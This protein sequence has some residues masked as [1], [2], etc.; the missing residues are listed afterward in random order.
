MN[1]ER[2]T[3]TKGKREKQSENTEAYSTRGESTPSSL[4]LPSGT[5]LLSSGP[6]RPLEVL[7]PAWKA[8][9]EAGPRG[10]ALAP[11]TQTA[12]QAGGASLRRR[13]DRETWARAELAALKPPGQLAVLLAQQSLAHIR[14]EGWANRGRRG[15]DTGLAGSLES[16]G[17]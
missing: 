10:A 4:W 16:G 11:V 3:G 2:E 1:R 14:Q 12:F 9:G 7:P 13:R 5:W 15:A 6:W 17:Q 8:A